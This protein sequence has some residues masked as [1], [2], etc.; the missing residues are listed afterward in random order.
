VIKPAKINDDSD[1]MLS[2]FKNKKVNRSLVDAKSQLEPEL[3]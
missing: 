1:L 2:E 3:K